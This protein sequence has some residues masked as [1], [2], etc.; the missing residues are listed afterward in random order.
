MGIHKTNWFV[1]SVHEV[2]WFAGS[3]LFSAW[4]KETEEDWELRARTMYGYREVE[5]LHHPEAIVAARRRDEELQHRKLM[6]DLGPRP[7][8]T[9]DPADIYS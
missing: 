1:C 6:A 8:E 3:G 7:R 9:E 2:C 4:L 5:P